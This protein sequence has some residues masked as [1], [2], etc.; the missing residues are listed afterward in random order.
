MLNVY[1]TMTNLLH[2]ARLQGI[3][4]VVFIVSKSSAC[5]DEYNYHDF[6]QGCVIEGIRH[7]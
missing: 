6:L 3:M 1:C 5:F 7:F 4:V 2:N